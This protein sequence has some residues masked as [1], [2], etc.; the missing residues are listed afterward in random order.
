MAIQL[1]HATLPRRLKVSY[2]INA[3]QYPSLS[4]RLG[5][6]NLIYHGFVWVF[7]VRETFCVYTQTRTNV[8][9]SAFSLSLF[10]LLVRTG[11]SQLNA[12]IVFIVDCSSDVPYRAYST[13]KAFVRSLTQYLNIQPDGSR[14]ALIVYGSRA[15]TAVRLEKSATFGSELTKAPFLAGRRRFDRALSSA[16]TVFEKARKNVPKILMLFMAGKQAQVTGNAI[17]C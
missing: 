11:I 8:V 2:N 7:V 12:D 15:F 5:A 10:I 3:P 1:I 16:S 13:Q 4:I 6:K 17:R 9:I 14:A